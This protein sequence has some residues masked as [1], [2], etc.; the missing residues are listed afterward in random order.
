MGD[1]GSCIL[2]WPWTQYV[3]SNDLKLLILLPPSPEYLSSRHESTPLPVA[4]RMS[5][6]QGYSFPGRRSP[7]AWKAPTQRCLAVRAGGWSELFPLGKAGCWFLLLVGHSTKHCAQPL[8]VKVMTNSH[9]VME[10]HFPSATNPVFWELVQGFRL[11]NA[12]SRLLI[13]KIHVCVNTL[14]SQVQLWQPVDDQTSCLGA[15]S[16]VTAHRT[17]GWEH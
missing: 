17:T 3:A 7:L 9:K 13:F 8:W 11:C 15:T 6:L 10:T 5:T 14:A 2:G 16:P 12:I 1:T 4:L